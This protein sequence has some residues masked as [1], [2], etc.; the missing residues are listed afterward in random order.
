MGVWHEETVSQNGEGLFGAWLK[1][2]DDDVVEYPDLRGT[3]KSY[4]TRDSD[5]K[6]NCEPHLAKAF[7]K[8]LVDTVREIHEEKLEP[9]EEARSNAGKLEARKLNVK[10]GLVWEAVLNLNARGE[11]HHIADDAAASPEDNADQLESEAPAIGLIGLH[12][13]S[14]YHNPIPNCRLYFEIIAAV[15]DFR[16]RTS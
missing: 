3:Q 1:Q 8:L 6:E 5:S 10:R 14:L 16:V 15:N 9:P 4:L 2:T 11:A 12:C 13:L 7:R